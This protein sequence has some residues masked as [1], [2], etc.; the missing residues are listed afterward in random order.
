MIKDEDPFYNALLENSSNY[1]TTAIGLG[2]DNSLP[3]YNIAQDKR[4][5]SNQLD[6]KLDYWNIL[7]KKSDLNL[8]LGTIYSKQDFDSEIFQYLS[9]YDENIYNYFGEI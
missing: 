6:A 7:N 1:Q 3:F 9:E 2:L 4:V 5:K 8:T